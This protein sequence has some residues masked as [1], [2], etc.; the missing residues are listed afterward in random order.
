MKNKWDWRKKH[1]LTDCGT[2]TATIGK[3][4]STEALKMAK[5]LILEMVLDGISGFLSVN[6]Q[7]GHGLWVIKKQR[8]F[9]K[10][11]TNNSERYFG[12]F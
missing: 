11:L 8:D 6:F 7:D 10:N 3:V 4:H 1:N 12:I 2:K 9:G 5:V